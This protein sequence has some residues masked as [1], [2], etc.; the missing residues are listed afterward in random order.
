MALT[1]FWRCESTTLDATHDF[2]A[3]D[4]VATA[5]GGV[6]ISASAAKTGSN[7]I[8][9]TDNLDFYLLDAAGIANIDQGAMGCWVQWKTAVPG[10]GNHGIRLYDAANPTDQITLQSKASQEFGCQI[11]KTGGT[12]PAL[13]TTAVNA[14]I[15]TWY[16]VLMRWHLS[17]DKRRLEVYNSAGSLIEAVEDL[18]T[19]LSTATPTVLDT[20]RIGNASSA[21]NP[22]WYD[23]VFISNDYNEPIQNN[24]AITS[25]T[26]YVGAATGVTSRLG[27]LG[28]G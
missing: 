14:V 13:T 23:L 16:F 10:A 28:V 18:A 26:A 3:G 5:S 9:T 25:Y 8:A 1:F 24:L 12:S 20:I 4:N 15:N 19:D 21:L 6:S 27:L 7:G 17:A 22:E 11:E 2:T